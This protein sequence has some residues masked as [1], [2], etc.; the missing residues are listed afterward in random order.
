[1][2][3]NSILDMI[4]NTPLLKLNN[5]IG[6]NMADIYLK[7]EKSNP[8][9]SVKDRAVLG[10]VEKAESE[11]LLKPGYTIVEPTSG[12][13]GIALSLIGKLKGYNVVIA[14]E[15]NNLTQ[16]K[17]VGPSAKSLGEARGIITA[18]YQN[19]L[20]ARWLETLRNK[21]NVQLHEEVLKSIVE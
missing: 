10:M 13:T 14:G 5:L 1:M 11:G 17:V 3:F 12:N 9:G 2:L 18:D 21:Y 7:L 20:E 6:N 8:A 15:G 4:G 16:I 19:Y